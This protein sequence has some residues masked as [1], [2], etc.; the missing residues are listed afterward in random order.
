MITIHD[1]IIQGSLEWHLLRCGS[2][3]A[4]R[5]KD[6][7]AGGQGKSRQTLAYQLAA[8]TVTGVKSE[9]NT[10]PAMQHGIDTEPEARRFFEFEKDVTVQEVGLVTNDKYPGMHCS[11]DGLIGDDA[12][13]EVKCPQPATHV[14]YLTEG[15][16]PPEYVCQVQFSMMICERN[17]WY[18]SSYHPFF[19]KQLILEVEADLKYIAELESKLE[20]FMAELKE[21]LTKIGE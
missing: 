21:I 6:A 11:P 2:L 17:I 14:K 4:S 5:A 15:R 13:Y 7:I 1:N 10:T 16:L 3:G 8:E 18:F 19:H 9:F 20:S 12:G